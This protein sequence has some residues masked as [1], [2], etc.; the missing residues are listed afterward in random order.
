MDNLSQHFD[1]IEAL[2]SIYDAEWKIENNSGTVYS[3]QVTPGVKLFI[4]F[5]SEYPSDKPP[6]YEMTAPALTVNQ[7]HRIEIEFQKI[8]KWV[9]LIII[10][11]YTVYLYLFV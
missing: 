5:I 1:E 8:Y 3:M 4:T 10:I 2:S 7:K 11:V 6:K 9:H